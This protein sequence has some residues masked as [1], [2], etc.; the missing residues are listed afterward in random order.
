MELHARRAV[1]GAGT[2]GTTLALHLAKQGPVVLLARDEQQARQLLA[3]R[4]N[5]RYL[6]GIRLPVELELTADPSAIAGA[7]DLVVFAVPS[8]AMRATA[9]RVRGTSCRAGGCACRSPRASSRA[10]DCA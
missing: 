7:S 6:P 9:E 2:W 1:I 4:E 8:A 3:D 10:A 5:S